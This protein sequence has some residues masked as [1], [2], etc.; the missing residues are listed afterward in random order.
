MRR[1]ARTIAL[2][3][4]MLVPA[5]AG[6]GER[7]TLEK[8]RDDLAAATDP[9]DRAKIVRQIA[10]FPDESAVRI[11]ARAAEEDRS[12]TV[13]VTAAESL[14]GMDEP[15]AP[16]ALADLA[17]LGGVRRF[18]AAVGAGL[19]RCPRGV[20][21][22]GK[23]LERPGLAPL[24]VERL[25][26][27]LGDA[28]T[29]FAVA[30]LDFLA[31]SS[32]ATRRVAALRALRRNKKTGTEL[33]D[34][35]GEMLRRFPD[36]DTLRT[37]LDLAADVAGSEFRAVL[38]GL[39]RPADP[40][41]RQA[42]T[43]IEARLD[44]LD[45]L[46][47]RRELA[48]QGAEYAPAEDDG[49]A[50]VPPPPPLRVDLVYLFDATGS[51]YGTL[52]ELRRRLDDEMVRWTSVGADLRVAVVAFRDR[53]LESSSKPTQFLPFTYDVDRVRAFLKDLRTTGV[54]A[55]GTDVGVALR[56]GLDR[57]AWR[58]GAR[59]VATL[60]MDTKVGDPERACGV[61]ASHFREDGTRLSV[62]WVAHTRK[63]IPESLVDLA[64]AG[65]GDQSTVT[66]PSG[67][68]GTSE[69]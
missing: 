35:L 2:A 66:T 45:A 34:A 52:E 40:G 8:L 6:A 26:D 31:R 37:T 38:R 15:H 7:L 47:R 10:E 24:D 22:V 33:R 55:Q 30:Q 20:E 11:L 13:R 69:R 16:D 41:A 44:Y 29:A 58:D 9:A 68:D 57:M 12:L 32:D 67:L 14:G 42:L 50:P 54:D 61:A 36:A 62:W 25:V 1:L 63:K 49:A 3:L 48:R 4:S 21:C 56:L 43:S 46:A 65:G 59:R 51:M 18:R 53:P 27:V 5:A 28:P 17:L 60:V 64:L 39:P 19:A 23:R